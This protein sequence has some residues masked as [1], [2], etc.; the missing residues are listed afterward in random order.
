MDNYIIIISLSSWLHCQNN[1]LLKK[2]KTKN[3]KDTKGTQLNTRI[4]N[5]TDDEDDE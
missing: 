5:P 1:N 3:I 4:E 2:T